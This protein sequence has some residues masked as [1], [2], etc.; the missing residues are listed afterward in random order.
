MRTSNFQRNISFVSV[1]F[2]ATILSL[3]LGFYFADGNPR[4]SA[5]DKAKSTVEAEE[6]SQI[7]AER[8]NELDPEERINVQVYEKC[9]KSTVNIDTKSVQQSS[10]FF[11]VA[12]EIE[13]ERGSGIV[14]DKKGHILTN[15]H[16]VEGARE[17]NV[18]LFNGKSYVAEMIG[19]DPPTDIAVMKIDAPEDELFPV[20]IADSSKLLV[21]QKVYAIGN[22]FGLERTLTSGII[23]SL[24]RTIGSRVRNRPIKQVIQ[25]DAA[26]NPGN[27][28]GPLLD[29]KGRMI[30]M[31]TAIASRVGENSGVGFAI[32]TNNIHRI[33]PILVKEGKVARAEIGLQIFETEDGLQIR[34]VKPDGPADRAGLQ[35]PKLVDKRS[36]RGGFSIT[37]RYIDT[38]A[39]DLITAIDDVPVKTAEDFFTTIESHKAGDRVMISVLRDGKTVKVPVVLENP[40]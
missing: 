36:N 28:G 3:G 10:L 31:N 6:D 9:N 21:G 11:G 5:Q 4:V 29:S 24:N 19:V 20:E 25:I 38:S 12:A 34:A 35:G 13:A 7:P 37:Q 33:V 23:S 15:Y 8:L 32:P 16:V 27:S 14:I 40:Q 18:T 17:V 22:P 30:G 2:F 1:L 39:A 26:I